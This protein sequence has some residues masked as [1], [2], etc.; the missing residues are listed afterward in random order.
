M[1]R[2]SPLFIALFGLFVAFV[3]TPA[4]AEWSTSIERDT[5]TGKR[6]G[7]AFSDN[8]TAK[9]KMKSPYAGIEA[10]LGVGCVGFQEW[11]YVGFSDTPKLDKTIAES[12]HSLIRTKIRWDGKAEDVELTQDPGSSVLH[13]HDDRA[14]IS[15]IARSYTVVLDLNW[16]GEGRRHFEFSLKGSSAALARI[17]RACSGK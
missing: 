13:F 5:A 6:T 10:W 17:R 16:H 2:K 12:G 15:E 9:E 7:Y 8:A 11:A 1:N 4:F 14:V 3:A